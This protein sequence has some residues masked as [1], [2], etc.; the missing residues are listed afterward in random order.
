MQTE[1]VEEEK[2]LMQTVQKTKDG[3][4][5]LDQAVVFK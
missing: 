1:D 2:R 5:E 3:E 4:D